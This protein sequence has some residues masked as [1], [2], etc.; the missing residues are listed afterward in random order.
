[1][2]SF[3]YLFGLLEISFLVVGFLFF[4]LH[5]SE[6]KGSAI[7]SEKSVSCQGQVVLCLV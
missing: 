2:S 7:R 4:L 6:E 3:L 1:M 5:F